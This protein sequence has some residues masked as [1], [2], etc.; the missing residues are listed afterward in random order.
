MPIQLLLTIGAFV[1]NFWSAFD[2]M[3]K[4]RNTGYENTEMYITEFME[5]GCDEEKNSP[6]KQ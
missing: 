2:L 5:S 3:R 6:T 4:K 1:N